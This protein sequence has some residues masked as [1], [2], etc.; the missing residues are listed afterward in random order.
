MIKFKD[1]AEKACWAQAFASAPVPDE[2]E[3]GEGLEFGEQASWAAEYADAAVLEFRK[4][5]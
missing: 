1:D 5:V 4:R 2:D 3:D